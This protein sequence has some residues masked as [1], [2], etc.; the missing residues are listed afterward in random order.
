MSERIA[1]MM[2]SLFAS[3]LAPR[4]FCAVERFDIRDVHRIAVD[5]PLGNVLFPQLEGD[6][7]LPPAHVHQFGMPDVVGLAIGE[8]D[9][10]WP[11]G[12][13]S[14]VISDLFSTLIVD[15]G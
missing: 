6:N 4:V 3:G 9:T 11:K 14:Q 8:A 5:R 2:G 1:L 15:V 13:P 12:L 10:K 7:N